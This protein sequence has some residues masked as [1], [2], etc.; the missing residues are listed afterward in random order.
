MSRMEDESLRAAWER[1]AEQWTAWARTPGHDVG[2]EVNLPTMLALLPPPGRLTL[3]LGCGEGRLLRELAQRGHRVLG[4]DASPT[5]ARAAHGHPRSQPVAVADAAA[6]PLPDGV[7]D[8]VVAHMSLQDVDDLHGA[9]AEIGRVLAPGGRLCAAVVHPLNSAGTFAT[10]AADAPFV[11]AGSYLEPHRY[12]DEVAREGLAMTF[13]SAHR[14]LETYA[15]ACEQA[16]LL[17]ET[18]REPAIGDE[19]VAED[20]S[21][22]RWR[23]V[24]LFLHWRAV[25]TG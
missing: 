7:A 25:K 19:Q 16:G 8:L 14:P 2:W 20:P 17:L 22:A 5:L 13:H 18:L 12:A 24:P 11:V 10:R 23:R 21:M 9:V 15:R 3:D 4:V 6:L 1:H